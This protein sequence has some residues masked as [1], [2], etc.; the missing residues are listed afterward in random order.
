MYKN[1]I[2]KRIRKQYLTHAIIPLS[3]IVCLFVLFILLSHRS[4]VKYTNRRIAIAQSQKISKI[5]SDYQEEAILLA[6]SNEIKDL[7]INN[8]RDVSNNIFSDFYAF[9]NSHKVKSTLVILNENDVLCLTSSTKELTFSQILVLRDMISRTDKSDKGVIGESSFLNL[10]LETQS[11]YTFSSKVENNGEIIGHVFLLLNKDDLLSALFEAQVNITIL[12]DEF[13]TVIATTNTS[14]IQAWNRFRPKIHA[15]N[16]FKIG[17]DDF[18]IFSNKVENTSLRIY[19]LSALNSQS[20]IIIWLCMFL[21]AIVVML[22]F[23]MKRLGNDIAQKTTEPIDKMIEAIKL[24][25][26]GN[27][28][29]YVKIETNDEFQLLADQYNLMLERINNLISKNT[30]LQEIKRISELKLLESQFNPHFMFNILECIRF[31]IV[32][33]PKSAQNIILTLSSLLRYSVRVQESFVPLKDDLEYINN[34]LLL[35]KFRVEDRLKY[36]IEIEEELKNIPI[37][38]LM[39]QPLIEN[40]VKYGFKKKMELEIHLKIYLAK[41]NNKIKFIIWDN[42]GGI[43]DSKLN[44]IN[45]MIKTQQVLKSNHGIGLYN[46]YRRLFLLYGDEASLVL[47]NKDN[48]LLI[49]IDIPNKG[50][51]DV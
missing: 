45:E 15:D 12:V 23:M 31:E 20:R 51:K 1:S 41:D 48:G 14:I 36:T 4:S 10:D 42:G 16:I 9:T 37:P 6:N 13:D 46:L 27:M 40:S 50:E 24:L 18:V 47:N 39:L 7:I 8:N 2:K 22:F 49:E 43:K 44:E 35:H 29:S 21:V 38:R 33:N 32:L 28:Q 3:I 26:E 11:V 19:C 30:E 17:S 5:M 25:Q 34:F